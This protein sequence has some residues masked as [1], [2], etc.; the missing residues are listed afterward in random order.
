MSLEARGVGH[1]Y[2][3]GRPVLADVNLRIGSGDTVAFVGPSGSGK[4]TLISILGG[5]LRPTD[6]EVVLDGAPV[7]HRGFPPATV[8]WVFQTANLFGHRT[9]MDNVAIG[10]YGRGSPP[11]EAA[12]TAERVLADVGLKGFAA[13]RANTL[14]GGE[15]QR[16]GI[17]RALASQ[18]R[19]VLADE[20]TGQLDA[21]TSRQIQATLLDARPADTALVLA[22]HD[23]EFAA[24]CERVFTIRN[25]CLEPRP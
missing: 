20:P 14:S 16:V 25:G 5:L 7:S 11:Q 23:L 1:Q 19:F 21:E 22:T 9:A 18:P 12:A 13:R 17:A 8:A 15:A 24:R 3:T 4:T 6:G 2:R 10:A